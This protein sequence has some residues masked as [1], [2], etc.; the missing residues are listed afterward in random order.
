[1][2]LLIRKIVLIGLLM[3]ANFLW[4]DIYRSE[5]ANGNISFSDRASPE[6]RVI[7]LEVRTYRYKHHV[8][9]VYDGDTIVLK[10]GE[11]VRLLGINTPEIESR[12]RQGEAGGEA[13]K[14]WLQTKLAQGQVFLEYDQQKRDKYKRLLAH[15]FLESG[16]HL[17]TS[18][19]EKGLATLSIIPPNLG[20]IND[21]IAAEKL[22]SSKGLGIW[23]M[24]DYAPYPILKLSK[25]KKSSGWHRFIGTPTNI[26]KSRKYIRLVLSKHVDIRISKDNLDLFPDLE[27]YLGKPLEIRGWASRSKTHYSILVRHP[28]AII[29]AL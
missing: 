2:A 14:K 12:H 23:S 6:A 5:D 15:L 22:A 21:L 10:N 19:V 9:K 24:P 17:N 11:K 8:A 29:P 3:Q 18:L 25:E 28:S 1:M 26:K 27:S 13:A 7:D 20:Y 16:E 4:A